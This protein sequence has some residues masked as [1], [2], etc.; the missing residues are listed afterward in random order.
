[1]VLP[2]DQDELVRRI[3]AANPRTVVVH[4]SGS[5]MAMPWA[6]DVAAVLQAWYP[7]QEGGNA[8]A[9]VLV[10][11]VDPAGRMPTT[12]PKRLEDTP[13]F[14][15]YPGDDGHA[16]YGEG[17]LLGYRWYLEHGIE[18]QWWFGHGLS[19]TTFEWGDAAATRDRATVEVTNTGERR[20]TEVVQAYVDRPDG[21][22][23]AF[24]GV[25]K[26]TLDPGESATVAVDLSPA[27]F[28]RWED[29]WIAPD[30]PSTV[31]LGRSVSSI[32]ATL[33]VE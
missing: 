25:A 15:W 19:Y 21:A 4:N 29:G 30:G 23:R 7:G 20:G 11:D 1:M 27:V 2:G 24:A 32:E 8:V 6:D 16:K 9:D 22:V 17:L 31:L 12:W 3:A 26:V 10:G 5:P 18:P 28:R 13:A 33:T 14:S